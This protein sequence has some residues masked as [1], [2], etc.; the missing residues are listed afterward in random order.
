[1]SSFGVYYRDVLKGGQA[2]RNP[3]LSDARLLARLQNTALSIQIP[4]DQEVVAGLVCRALELASRLP[5]GQTKGAG[6][7]RDNPQRTR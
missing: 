7:V 1:M 4:V 6:G 5:L 3:P 2:A